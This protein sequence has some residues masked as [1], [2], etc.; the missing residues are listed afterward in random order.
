M[1]I[2]LVED[3]RPTS[4][5]IEKMLG[6]HNYKVN[7]ATDGISALELAQSFDFDL[8]ILDIIIPRLDGISV[9]QQ[10]RNCGYQNPILLLTAKDSSDQRVIGLNAGADDY[11]VKPF[12]LPELLARIRALLRRSKLVSSPIITWENLRLDSINN[13]ITCNGQRLYLTPKEYCLLE[14]FLLNPKRIFSRSTI[15]DRLWDFAK[16]PGEETVSVH[17]KCLR[18]KLKAAGAS[19]PIETVHG[20]GYRLKQP[21]E[22]KHTVATQLPEPNGEQ[23]NLRH[24]VKQ[25]TMSIWDKH[26]AHVI[27]QVTLLEQ[28]SRLLSVDELT[29]ELR[30]QAQHQAHKLAGS[31]GIFGLA[32]GSQLARELE[33]LLEPQLMLEAIQIQRFAELTKLL[34]LQLDRLTAITVAK[35]KPKNDS[36]LILIVDDDLLLAEQLRIEGEKKGMRVEVATDVAVA[37]QAIVQSPPDVILVD[38]NFPSSTENGLTLLRRLKN[39]VSKIPTIVFTGRE[40]LAD[41]IEVARLGIFAFLHKPLP[42]DD[43]FQTINDVLYPKQTNSH[44]RVMLVDDDSVIL[45]TLS[46][47][48]RSLE[49]EVITLNNP[50]QFWEV[51]N[52]FK[53][54]LLVLDMKMPKF[55]GADLCLVVRTDPYWQ[56]LIVVFLSTHTTEEE[57]D[58]AFAVGADD[59][60]SKSIDRAEIT[61]RII[62]RL[63]KGKLYYTQ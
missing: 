43:I 53:P 29:A 56:N 37:Q 34:R 31:L 63:Q 40:S 16:S 21:D 41:R 52:S 13:E 35:A 47:Y 10:L 5:V 57:I 39:R 33:T 23:E 50:Q 51:L 45:E 2:L 25:R 32:E 62:R 14:L 17:I 36:P 9:C 22:L 55:N 4:S 24:K 8:I 19:N 54:N 27:Q 26:K 48:L 7:L 49:C 38:L 6:D 58:L 3:D 46:N 20:L 15:L 12:D 1:K 60:I 11:V 42:A 28:A 61:T 44:H 59:Y 30:Q 18:Q